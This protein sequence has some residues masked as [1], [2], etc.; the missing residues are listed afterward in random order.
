MTGIHR[1]VPDLLKR[2]LKEIQAIHEGFGF[3]DD[4][5]A[6]AGSLSVTFKPAQGNYSTRVGKQGVITVD[7][8]SPETRKAFTAWHE[9]CHELFSRSRSEDG[10]DLKEDVLECC[11]FTDYNA[12][13]VEEEF[14]DS[15]ASVLLFPHHTLS[16]VQ[17]HGY[18]PI[19]A[20]R[21]RETRT[22]S[23]E[24]AARRIAYH[25]GHEAFVYLIEQTGFVVD[26]FCVAT[27]Y[28]TTKNYSISQGH[29]VLKND[30]ETGTVWVGRAPL[31]FKK[32]ERDMGFTAAATRDE[33]GRTLAF[34]TRREEVFQV[35]SAQDNLFS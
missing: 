30:I 12:I 32:G 33:R 21:L 17:A 2:F 35:N 4:Y 6:V 8:D 29:P 31:P 13:Q 27:H 10:V 22:S 7:A 20:M 23:V 28:S 9:I 18:G 24:A 16:H 14:C 25:H 5:K 34:F 19:A 3:T 26:S 1:Q 15:G 11:K